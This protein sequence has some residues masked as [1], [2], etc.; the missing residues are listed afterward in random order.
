M[1]QQ[2]AIQE[3]PKNKPEIKRPFYLHEQEKICNGKDG[4][5]ELYYDHQEKSYN[6]NGICQRDTFCTELRIIKHTAELKEQL[7]QN[8]SILIKS[9]EEFRDC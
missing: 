2:W 9:Y 6:P 1:F 8:K 5:C 3:T 7:E 4:Q